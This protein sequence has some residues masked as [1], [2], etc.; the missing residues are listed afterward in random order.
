[1]LVKGETQVL[2]SAWCV[3]LCAWLGVGVLNSEFW[4]KDNEFLFIFDLN[5][6]HLITSFGGQIINSWSTT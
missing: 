3:V 4:I 2:F 6:V 5:A 1:M